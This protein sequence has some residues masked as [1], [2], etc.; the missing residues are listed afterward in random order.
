MPLPCKS[1]CLFCDWL[2]QH[3]DFSMFFTLNCFSFFY[4]C[5]NVKLHPNLQ[6]GPY[7]VSLKFPFSLF[8][9]MLFLFIIVQVAFMNRWYFKH[10]NIP[11]KVENPQKLICGKITFPL[12]NKQHLF[13]KWHPCTICAVP[14]FQLWLENHST[15]I[16]L[17]FT[18]YLLLRCQPVYALDIIQIQYFLQGW[19]YSLNGELRKATRISGIEDFSINV[20]HQVL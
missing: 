11:L 2:N 9:F 8:H 15:F 5:L 16:K 6:L 1:V 7:D 17:F 18:Y 4:F 13:Y 3:P 12:L 19:T 14:M 20:F 10:P